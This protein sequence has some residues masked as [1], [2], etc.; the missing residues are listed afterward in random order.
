MNFENIKFKVAQNQIINMASKKKAI[1]TNEQLKREKFQRD[2][3]SLPFI[4]S[5]IQKDIMLSLDSEIALILKSIGFCNVL[6]EYYVNNNEEVV[7][8]AKEMD[9]FLNQ[10][11][12]NYE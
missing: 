6:L 8:D 4:P 2:L 7:L 3:D 9:F 11:V 1:L 12:L 5:T 10:A